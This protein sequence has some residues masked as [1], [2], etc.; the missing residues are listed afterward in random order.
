MTKRNKIILELVLLAV[1]AACAVIQLMIF[2]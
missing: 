2:V 1:A